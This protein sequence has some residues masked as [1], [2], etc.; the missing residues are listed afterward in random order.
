MELPFSIHLV[1]AFCHRKRNLRKRPVACNVPKAEMIQN[2]FS[3]K[4]RLLGGLAAFRVS[5]AERGE[6]GLGGAGPSGARRPAGRRSAPRGGADAARTRSPS[7]ERRRITSQSIGPPRRV[8]RRCKIRSFSPARASGITVVSVGRRTGL[9][10][11][12]PMLLL[13]SAAVTV[14]PRWWRT[15]CCLQRSG[16]HCLAWSAGTP[17]DVPL[18]VRSPVFLRVRW[19]F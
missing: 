15:P 12:F 11:V 4:G 18:R 8:H 17:P 5:E 10:A 7:G 3:N 19:A 1:P 9:G 14:T 6:G 16:A 13:E 2:K